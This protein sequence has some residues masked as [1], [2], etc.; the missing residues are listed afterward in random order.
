MKLHSAALTP[1]AIEITAPPPKDLKDEAFLTLNSMD[2]IP[3]VPLDDGTVIPE[4]AAI[5]AA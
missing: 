4:S 1:F 2:P 5:S 3:A